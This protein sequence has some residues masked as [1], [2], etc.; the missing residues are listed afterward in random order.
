MVARSRPALPEGILVVTNTS[1]RGTP[2]SRTARPT[3]A[4]LRYMVAVS[5]CR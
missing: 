1:S 3:S 5:M 4:S 2:L